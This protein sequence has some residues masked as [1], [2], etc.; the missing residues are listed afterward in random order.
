MK[1]QLSKDKAKIIQNCVDTDDADQLS[2]DGAS[3]S[4]VTLILIHRLN[5]I[6]NEIVPLDWL[7]I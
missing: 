6:N 7:E 3:R 2:S 1:I 4:G 5:L